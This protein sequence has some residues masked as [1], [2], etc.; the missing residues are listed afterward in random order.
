MLSRV[1]LCSRSQNKV[2]PRKVLLFLRVAP[3]PATSWSSSCVFLPATPGCYS[4]QALAPQPC[5][6]WCLGRA[7]HPLTFWAP[8][9]G[10]DR[11]MGRN[12][13][14]AMR[15][16]GETQNPSKNNVPSWLCTIMV[17]QASGQG[18]GLFKNKERTFASLAASICQA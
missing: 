7:H 2:C 18:V 15:N 16:Y 3:S 9:A 17:L 13:S 1:L 6:Y 8:T 12:S 4:Q 10:S 14:F 5:S 11:A